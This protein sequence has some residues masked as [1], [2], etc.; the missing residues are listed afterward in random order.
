M[1]DTLLFHVHLEIFHNPSEDKPFAATYSSEKS[2]YHHSVITAY[3]TLVH[4]IDRAMI[5]CY[6]EIT[7]IQPSPDFSVWRH[8]IVG[9]VY[10]MDILMKL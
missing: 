2:V 5:A 8:M 9:R 7:K 1:E 6:C 3:V 4:C 10:E